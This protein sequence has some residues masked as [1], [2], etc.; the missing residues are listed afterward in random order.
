VG[1]CGDKFYCEAGADRDRDDCLF[2]FKVENAKRRQL[3]NVPRTYPALL[4]LLNSRNASSLDRISSIWPDGSKQSPRKT[5]SRETSFESQPSDELRRLL[6]AVDGDLR[7]SWRP[8][9]PKEEPE[10]VSS[11]VERVSRCWFK[12]ELERYRKLSPRQT[13]FLRN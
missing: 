10:P 9:M 6:G 7:V 13:R 12:F 4:Y 8:Y 2:V 1:L 5:P 11:F 3:R